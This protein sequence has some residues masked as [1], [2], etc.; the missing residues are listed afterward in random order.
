MERHAAN[1]AADIA[2]NLARDAQTSSASINGVRDEGKKSRTPQNHRFQF[3]ANVR[4]LDINWKIRGIITEHRA[5]VSITYA[6]A[7]PLNFTWSCCSMTPRFCA[8]E[9]EV[10]GGS[11]VPTP[12]IRVAKA[13]PPLHDNP[14]QRILLRAWDRSKERNFSCCNP[15]L[16]PL[17]FAA[18]PH[19]RPRILI[20][21]SIRHV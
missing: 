3:L 1:R 21:P 10:Q 9:S 12:A 4:C 6:L 20:H 13:F 7:R 18:G 11:L 8:S 14:C 19:Q 16:P 15:A 5:Q 17:D 2:R